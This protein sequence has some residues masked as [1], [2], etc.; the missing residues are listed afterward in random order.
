VDLFLTTIEAEQAYLHVDYSI[1]GVACLVK[2]L[3]FVTLTV[4]WWN[5]MVMVISFSGMVPTEAPTIPLANKNRP[6]A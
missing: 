4:L 3:V 2:P 1:G 5:H 6:V